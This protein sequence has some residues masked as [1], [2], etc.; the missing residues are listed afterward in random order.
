MVPP[1]YVNFK[2]ILPN[3]TFKKKKISVEGLN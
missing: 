3:N 2:A 1:E